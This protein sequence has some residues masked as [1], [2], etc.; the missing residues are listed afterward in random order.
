MIAGI[1]FA[2]VKTGSPRYAVQT[3]GWGAAAS[4][5]QTYGNLETYALMGAGAATTGVNQGY[6]ITGGVI[7]RYPLKLGWVVAGWTIEKSSIG[8]SQAMI[9]LGWGK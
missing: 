5:L 2:V 9:K 1:D 4:P 3:A 8:G 7:A 6:V